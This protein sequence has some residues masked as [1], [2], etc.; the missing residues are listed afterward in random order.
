MID[1]N[2]AYSVIS[3]SVSTM[4]LEGTR[5]LAAVGSWM[6]NKK[7]KLG[8]LKDEDIQTAQ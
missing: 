7:K 1:G 4:D 5:E 8:D 6:G 3:K 2:Q